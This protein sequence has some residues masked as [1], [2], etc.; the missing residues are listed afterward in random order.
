MSSIQVWFWGELIEVV[1][2]DL[3]CRSEVAEGDWTSL[4]QVPPKY[5]YWESPSHSFST[6]V[7]VSS[8]SSV[9]LCCSSPESVLFSCC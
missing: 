7:F 4:L 9:R 1:S 5:M 6:T 2:K 3:I 8:C